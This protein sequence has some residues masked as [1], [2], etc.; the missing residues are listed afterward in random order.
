MGNA[1]ILMATIL[2]TAMPWTEL[3]WNFDQFL[4]GGQD[5]E[6]SLLSI[7]TFLCLVLLL[8]FLGKQSVSILLA[9]RIW[10]WSVFEKAEV[11]AQGSFAHLL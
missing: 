6:F 3:H 9:L 2:L 5:F 10:L 1:L 8:T 7:I 4:H 11:I